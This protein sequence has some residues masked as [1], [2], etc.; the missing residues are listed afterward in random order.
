VRQESNQ[1]NSN[2]KLLQ[3]FFRLL[4][5][6]GRF[7]AGFCFVSFSCSKGSLYL[8][9]KKQKETA[10]AKIVAIADNLHEVQDSI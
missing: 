9:Q 7:A 2:S 3:N 1:A 6:P 5:T 4:A 10:A 8:C